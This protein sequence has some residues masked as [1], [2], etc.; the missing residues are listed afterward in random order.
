MLFTCRNIAVSIPGASPN[1][2]LISIV[3][4]N[5][6]TFEPIQF[7]SDPGC[8]SGAFRIRAIWEVFPDEVQSAAGGR[9]QITGFRPSDEVRILISPLRGENPLLWH[10]S[11][12]LRLVGVS[13]CDLLTTEIRSKKR[14]NVMVDLIIFQNGCV[15]IVVDPNVLGG[16][17]VGVNLCTTEIRSKNDVQ[18]DGCSAIS[19][20]LLRSVKGRKA[21]VIFGITK[22]WNRNRSIPSYLRW[23][24]QL[25]TAS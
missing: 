21:A 13:F 6:S 19:K 18:C 12:L 25:A 3:S 24:H 4:L 8:E 16:G 20:R 1:L 17:S 9:Y 22:H 15:K 14:C 5:T 10:I 23:F 7:R 11:L 2:A